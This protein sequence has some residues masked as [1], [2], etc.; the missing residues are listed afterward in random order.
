MATLKG[1]SLDFYDIRVK[2]EKDGTHVV[3]AEWVIDRKAKDLLVNYNSFQAV[4][5]EGTG[6]WSTD[7]Y[8]VQ[9]LV[10]KDI[11][12]FEKEYKAKTGA[13]TWVKSLKNWDSKAWT[14][15][16]RY[17]QNLPENRKDLDG[18]IVF[19]N[20]EIVKTDYATK[21]LPYSLEAGDYDAWDEIVG[22]LYTDEERA[23][24]E[25]AIGAIVSGDSINIQKF[26]VFYGKPGS[27]KSTI[28]DIIQLL[29]RGYSTIFDAKALTSNNNS[30]ATAPFKNN[31]LV[32]VQHDGDL[33]RIEDNTLLNM[34]TAHEDIFV[35]EK[36]MKP[37]S[38]VPKSFLFMGTNEPV[39]IRNAKAG[40][41]RRLIDVTPSG[42][43]IENHRYHDLKDNVQ[44]ELGGI[45][46]HCEQRYLKLGMNYY[47]RL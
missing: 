41:I 47:N 8:D 2:R 39:K 40:I 11:Y 45:A 16:Q 19:Q 21:R 46:Y 35:N 25:W 30:F 36:Y 9:R 26:L 34:L 5:D 31:P 12:Q 15:F 22:T 38:I 7:E 13:V 29:F 24:I 20:T 3:Y 42:H 37:I 6:L 27:G 10:D 14:G 18:K 44:F 32:A 28:L 4:W 33:S 23:K 17:V 43:I 1:G